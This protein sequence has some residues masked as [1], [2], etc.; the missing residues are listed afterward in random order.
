MIT[1]A[2][3]GGDVVG[4]MTLAIFPIYMALNLKSFG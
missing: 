4:T 3:L 2:L 1:V